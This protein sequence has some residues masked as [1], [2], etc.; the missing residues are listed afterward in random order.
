MMR[1]YRC[2]RL[3]RLDKDDVIFPSGHI[4]RVLLHARTRTRAKPSVVLAIRLH[5]GGR[6]SS[7]ERL[8]YN[9]NVYIVD[10]GELV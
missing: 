8:I 9:G 4:N 5:I 6:V 1:V 7:P 2:G 10:K 3:S